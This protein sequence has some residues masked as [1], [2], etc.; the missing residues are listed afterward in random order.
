MNRAEISYES[1]SANI[2]SAAQEG[3]A[4]R[5]VFVCPATGMRVEARAAIERGQG[6]GS[7]VGAAVRQGLLYSVRNAV[8]QALR[9]ALGYGILGSVG[10]E[11]A[12]A[13]MVG[14][15]APSF[16]EDERRAAVLRAFQG[17][18][19]R[20]AWDGRRWVS[21]EAQAETQT[22]FARQ[23]GALKLTSPYDRSVLARMLME[24][25]Q[26]DGRITQ[27]ERDLLGRFVAADVGPGEGRP[28]LSRAELAETS[29]GAREVALMVA[30][31]VALADSEL[32]EEEREKLGGHAAGLGI[33]GERAAV[34]KGY[35][36]AFLLDQA[37]AQVYAGGRRDE[38]AHRAVM[39]LA[40][41]IGLG[42]EEAERVDIRY[43]K[44]NGVF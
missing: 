20:F 37:L 34:L 13:A 7:A 33:S 27:E 28:A 44:R 38:A 25:A 26:A 11:V 1:I 2:E 12:S 43:R 17:V 4:M 23:L 18:S 36:Q 5:C 9:R 3:G 19:E 35:A 15:G 24:V 41:R 10:A 14:S 29:P 22:E 32:S 31:A 39:E 8:I 16:S 21:A 30:W 40:R 6:V 42:A